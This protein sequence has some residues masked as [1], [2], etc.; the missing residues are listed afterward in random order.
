MFYSKSIIYL[1]VNGLPRALK[2]LGVYE[3]SAVDRTRLAS[4]LKLHHD[5][6]ESEIDMKVVE[7]ASLAKRSRA[8]KAL[9]DLP[10][11]YASRVELAILAK[12]IEP[13]YAIGKVQKYRAENPDDPTNEDVEIV[14]T[15]YIV[16][17]LIRG[18]CAK[19]LS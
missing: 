15:K 9:I 12:G 3:L 17:A 10:I 2:R 19:G 18:G 7:I 1:G 13:Y 4:I 8:S 6:T 14:R 16:Q 5:P 11:F